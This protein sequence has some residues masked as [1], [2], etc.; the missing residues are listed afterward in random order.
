MIQQAECFAVDV[1]QYSCME[2]WGD[3]TAEG[4]D[5][6]MLGQTLCCVSL[7]VQHK[8]HSLGEGQK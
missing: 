5:L 7:E 1:D 2:L 6:G 3:L 4:A 8:W